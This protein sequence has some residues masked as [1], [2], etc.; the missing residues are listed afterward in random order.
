MPTCWRRRSILPKAVIERP[1]RDADGNVL[2]GVRLPDM[3]APLGVHAAQQEPKSFSCS[4]LG[5]FLPFTE[6]RIAELYKN[7]DDYVNR[8]RVAA[9][10]AGGGEA[11][12]ARGCRGDHRRRRRHALAAGGEEEE[13]EPRMLSACER[14]FV[15]GRRVAHLA[16]ADAQAVPHVVPVCFGLVEDALYITIDQKPKRAGRPLKRLRNIAENPARLHR[17]RPLRRGLAPPRLGDAARPG[18]DPDGRP[19]ARSR[20]GP[21]AARAIRSSRPWRSE[22]YPL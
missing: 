19:R 2:G 15:E 6:A 3:E 13:V 16:T 8:I 9:R 20:P 22:S 4:L 18:R 17:I 1:K 10:A 5:A 11:A 14:R 12:A 21:V 7:R